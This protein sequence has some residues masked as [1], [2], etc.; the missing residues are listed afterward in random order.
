M[1]VNTGKVAGCCRM[2]SH[3]MRKGILCS[4]ILRQFQEAL[5]HF[6]QA[7][8]YNPGVSQY[9]ENR[10]RIYNREQKLEE[11]KEDAIHAILLDPTNRQAGL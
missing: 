5:E 10:G 6:S 11:A 4:H 8:K 2:I 7:V 9:Y 1:A 3:S